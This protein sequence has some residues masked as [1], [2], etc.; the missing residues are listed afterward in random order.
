MKA[1]FIVVKIGTKNN[2]TT[3]E[4]QNETIRKFSDALQ[5]QFPNTPIQVVP[6]HTKVT[7]DGNEYCP[8]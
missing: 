7:I 2:P 3:L 5:S 4:A 6:E 8:K 1:E